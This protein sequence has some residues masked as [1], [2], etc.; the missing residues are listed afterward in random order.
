MLSVKR[1][2]NAD[3]TL[4]I[5]YGIRIS[6]RGSQRRRA[7]RH[8]K[9]AIEYGDAQ[10]MTAVMS[11][12]QS[13][14]SPKDTLNT[15][16][17]LALRITEATFE[18]WNAER[19][20]RENVRNGTPFFNGPSDERPLERHS[21]SSL[22]QC[23]RKLYYRQ[24]NAP[25]E[26]ADPKGIFWF[27]THFEENLIVPFL[28]HAIA[29][30]GEYVQNSIWIDYTVE[31]DAGELRIK[32]VTDPVLVTRTGISLLPSEIK[33]KSSVGDLDGPNEHHRAQVHAYLV[34]LNRKFD[35]DTS[36]D[37]AVIMYG[38]RET[39]DGQCFHVDFDREFWEETGDDWHRGGCDTL[40]SRCGCHPRSRRRDRGGLR[41]HPV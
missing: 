8:P 40:R 23:H 14:D 15:T 31:T 5:Q 6:Y 4:S 35:L 18:E 36:L 12:P 21:P 30:D 25:E 38:S 13:S 7:E 34:G 1:S 37:S 19:E 33:T 27:G 20:T 39:L 24:L 9:P 16:Q 28:E 11:T 32:G 2:A 29:R 26:S 17:E 41:S 22:L 10:E 3:F